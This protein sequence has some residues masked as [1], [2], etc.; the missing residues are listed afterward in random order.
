MDT[1]RVI[2]RYDARIA[3]SVLSDIILMGHENAGSYALADVKRSLLGQAMMT[4][5]DI[6]S[7]VLNRYAVPRLFALNGRDLPRK[8]SRGLSMV[9]W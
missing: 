7:E 1:E 2:Q 3:M 9:R 8:C 5:L 4:W 6:I